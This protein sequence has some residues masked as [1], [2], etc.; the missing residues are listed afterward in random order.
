MVCRLGRSHSNPSS[1]R[2]LSQHSLGFFNQSR[3]VDTALFFEHSAQNG[4]HVLQAGGHLSEGAALL[5]HPAGFVGRGHEVEEI[6]RG[7]C[8]GG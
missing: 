3:Y 8:G 6:R 7:Q 5:P 1:S 4:R 2:L